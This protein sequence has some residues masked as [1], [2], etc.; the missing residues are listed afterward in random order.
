MRGAL[1]YSK[2]TGTWV[3]E[4]VAIIVI[5]A[6]SKIIHPKEEGPGAGG[7]GATRKRVAK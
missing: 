7:A 3:R 2:A 5:A 1:T 6:D 4:A